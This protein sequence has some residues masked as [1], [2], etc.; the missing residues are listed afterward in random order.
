LK[1]SYSLTDTETEKKRFKEGA[2]SK[3]SWPAIPK[4]RKKWT[5]RRLNV[6]LFQGGY[7]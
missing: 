2:L 5:R 1:T 3:G 4:K 7:L 6:R